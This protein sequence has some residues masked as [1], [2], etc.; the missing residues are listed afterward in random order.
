MLQKKIL[1]WCIAIVLSLLLARFIFT[2]KSTTVD[3]ALLKNRWRDETVA[4][5]CSQM[6]PVGIPTLDQ[7]KN[8][9]IV[10]YPICGTAS[11]GNF[12]SAYIES[13]IC[14][15]L[16][17][18]HLVSVTMH[19]KQRTVKNLPYFFPKYIYNPAKKFEAKKISETCKCNSTICHENPRSLLHAHPIMVRDIIRPII[20][21]H[22]DS[23]LGDTASRPR[24]IV[25]W[26]SSLR[27]PFERRA[28][29]LPTVPEVAIHYRC[30]DNTV[31]HYGFLSFPAFTNR[32][33]RN[34]STIYVMAES[35]SRNQSP[36]RT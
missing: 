35:S 17:G 34:V 15:N 11:F 32:I 10:N 3:T 25:A 36:S 21:N 23:W 16:T 30:G 24:K 26:K 8:N 27:S 1:I 22:Y 4:I 2:P 28:L 31:G 13:R 18:M 5:N 19:L 9:T 12:L 14:A 29:N 33:P 7:I 20:L 6:K